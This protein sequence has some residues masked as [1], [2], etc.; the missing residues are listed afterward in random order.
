MRQNEGRDAWCQQPWPLRTAFQHTRCFILL[1]SKHCAGRCSSAR[2]FDQRYPANS[3]FV[4]GPAALWWGNDSSCDRVA[5]TSCFATAGV[6]DPD[7]CAG[8]ELRNDT[9]V[10][11]QPSL[12]DVH[13]E[14][15]MHVIETIRLH[16]TPI[17]SVSFRACNADLAHMRVVCDLDSLNLNCP[18]YLKV[19]EPEACGVDNEVCSAVVC[20]CP[21]TQT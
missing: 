3:G 4:E 20:K 5:A 1:L 9:N 14:G 19:L 6:A 18:H 13:G 21:F 17:F 11:F 10:A 8:H 12:D 16:T 15:A 2:T 7:A